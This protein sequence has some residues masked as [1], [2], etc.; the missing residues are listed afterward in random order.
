MGIVELA[1]QAQR[2][3][4]SI[5]VAD[6]LRQAEEGSLVFVDVRDI[7]EMEKSGTIDGALH[8]P[9]GM[10]EFW[11][12]PQSPY[13]RE[14]YGQA[15]KTYVLFCNADWR[16]A[17]S[18]KSLQDMEIQNIAQLKGGLPAWREAGGA[19]AEKASKPV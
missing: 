8:A 4:Q 17:L 10:I 19:V 14:V 5:E 11:F 12:D 13:F 7:R 2:E 15:D 3:V 16:S 18:A 1:E 9:R 6:A